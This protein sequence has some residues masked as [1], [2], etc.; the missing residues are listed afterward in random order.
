MNP[1]SNTELR[2]RARRAYEWSRASNALAFGAIVATPAVMVSMGCC[3]SPATSVLCGVGLVATV[4]LARF[5]GLRFQAALRP[6]LI[7][8]SV[9]FAFPVVCRF[10]VCPGGMCMQGGMEWIPYVAV[11]A[12]FFGGLAIRLLTRE[13]SLV[14]AGGTALLLGSLGSLAAGLAGP[15]FTAAGLVAGGLIPVNTLHR[16]SGA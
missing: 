2:R 7:A 1:G 16:R 11:G 14:V 15:L 8:G 6:G 4:A 3:P 5:L 13:A 10:Y 9:A 12:A